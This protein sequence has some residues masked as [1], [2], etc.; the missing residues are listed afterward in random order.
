MMSSR[1]L[2]MFVKAH[3]QKLD[4]KISSSAA[5]QHDISINDTHATSS[6]HVRHSASSSHWNLRDGNMSLRRRPKSRY[7]DFILTTM[8]Q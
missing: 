2:K 5:G 6:M 7:F 8:H 3:E 1:S 4:A